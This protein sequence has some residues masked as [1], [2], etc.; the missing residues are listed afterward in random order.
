MKQ[1]KIIRVYTQVVF[2]DN[3]PP[4][5]VQKETEIRKGKRR[6]EGARKTRSI[7]CDRV[8]PSNCG[9]NRNQASA[10]SSTAWLGFV[11]ALPAETAYGLAMTQTQVWDGWMRYT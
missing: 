5:R 6:L 8:A 3:T 7:R 9:P 11:V 4:R 2:R 1:V 10:C